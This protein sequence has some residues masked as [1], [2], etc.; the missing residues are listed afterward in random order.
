MKKMLCIVLFVYCC[1]HHT[2]ARGDVLSGFSRTDPYDRAIQSNENVVLIRVDSEDVVGQGVDMQG[3]KADIIE[4]TAEVI[5]SIKGSFT[6]GQVIKFGNMV[7]PEGGRSLRSAGG[8]TVVANTFYLI[9]LSPPKASEVSRSGYVFTTVNRICSDSLDL[10]QAVSREMPAV[11]Q[12]ISLLATDF[13]NNPTPKPEDRKHLESLFVQS[14]VFQ[15]DD[16]FRETRRE[17]LTK[18]MSHKTAFYQKQTRTCRK[19]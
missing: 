4:Y 1:F 6:D 3:R 10:L 8:S 16:M 2:E 15:T 17:C 11:K 13:L 9:M 5:R 18:V 14:K 7:A 12:A 19:I